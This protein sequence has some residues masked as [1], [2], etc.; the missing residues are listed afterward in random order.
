MAKMQFELASATV[1]HI[2][3]AEAVISGLKA[4]N[5]ANNEIANAQKMSAY[6]ELIASL[7]GVKLVKGKLP[8]AISKQVKEALLGACKEA[9]AKRYLENSVGALRLFSDE[10]SSQATPSL[11]KELFDDPRNDIQSENKLAKIVSGE[12]EKSKAQRL[13]E[14]VVGKWS[15]KK[16]DAGKS[17]QGDVFKDGLSD[18]ELDEFQNAMRELMAAREAYRNTKAAKDAE[19]AAAEENGGVDAV[20][21]AFL[22][23]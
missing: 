8:R 3:K 22:D 23:E 11:V 14:S 12:A 1:D 4:D 17:V 15:T 5:K 9:T 6:H 2:A 20:V 18:E 7:S 16:D 13:A 19:A 10:L 21:A